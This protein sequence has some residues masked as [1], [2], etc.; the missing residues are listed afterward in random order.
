MVKAGGELA[1]MAEAERPVLD[2]RIAGMEQETGPRGAA[3]FGPEGEQA[4]GVGQ[5]RPGRRL[6]L[7]R[8]RSLPD[9]DD[10][11]DLLTGDGSPGVEID[12]LLTRIPPGQE[13]VE[14]DI[15]EMRSTGLVNA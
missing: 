7:D 15:L 11:I 3:I 6:H 14:D 9:L 12:P 5:P 2:E 10:E 1:E 13:I 8:D 4:G